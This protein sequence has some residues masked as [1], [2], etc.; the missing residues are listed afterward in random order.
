MRYHA[1]LL[2]EILRVSPVLR[3]SRLSVDINGE[4]GSVIAAIFVQFWLESHTER[5]ARL[6]I[7]LRECEIR[8]AGS[9]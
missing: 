7:K 8:A 5:H 6:R 4:E 2:S 3:R 9:L 1:I